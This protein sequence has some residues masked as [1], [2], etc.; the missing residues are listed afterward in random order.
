MQDFKSLMNDVFGA[1]IPHH[2]ID[3]LSIRAISTAYKELGGCMREVNT[4]WGLRDVSY[5]QA[6][7][8]T[9]KIVKDSNCNAGVVVSIDYQS[10][11]ATV[12][13]TEIYDSSD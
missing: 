11:S 8:F 10:R 4:W 2:N 6:A 9:A 1:E 7:L 3:P 5:L 12:K 13:L